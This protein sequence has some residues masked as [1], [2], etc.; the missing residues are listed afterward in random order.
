MREVIGIDFLLSY[1]DTLNMLVRLSMYSP[2]DKK[3]QPVKRQN[4]ATFTC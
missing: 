3:S 4:I 1:Y 2:G